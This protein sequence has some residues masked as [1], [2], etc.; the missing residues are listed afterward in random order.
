VRPLTLMI[1]RMQ[2]ESRDAPSRSGNGGL[3]LLTGLIGLAVIANSV[4]AVGYLSTSE[5][6][7]NRAPAPTVA[8]APAPDQ[9]LAPTALSRLL[10]QRSRAVVNHDRD[11]FLRTV[12]PV[13]AAFLADQR[14]LFDNLSRLPLANWSYKPVGMQATGRG[15]WWVQLSVRYRLRGFDVGDVVRRQYVHVVQRPRLGWVVAGNGTAYGLPDE[16]EV[17]DTGRLTVVKGRRSLVLG[18]DAVRSKLRE[19][20]DRVDAGVPVVSGV[21]GSDWARRA[22][23]LVPGTQEQASRLVGQAQDLGQIAA[24]ATVTGEAAH[25]ADRIVVAPTTFPRLNPLG[26]RVVLTHELTHIATGGARDTRTPMWLVEGL[27]DYVGYKDID[28]PV[29]DAARELSE[30]V[31]TGRLPGRLPDQ[32]DF[33]GSSPRLSEAYQEAW[34]ACRMIVERYGEDRLWRLYQAAGGSA[35]QAQGHG[36]GGAA[37]DVEP[38]RGPAAPGPGNRP[39]SPPDTAGGEAGAA[40]PRQREDRALRGVL[41][42]GT[43]AFVAMWRDYL[44]TE[45]GT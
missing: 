29:I 10:E 5:A 2:A 32:R 27:A 7:P 23:V 18:A 39:G 35:G 24:L 44:R 15:G 40:D 37:D 21:V 4:A 38:G 22:V 1:T 34:L 43:T 14:R 20:A 11:A 33:A 13:R 25:P 8:L 42:V 6:P 17:W 16:P 30:E 9:A 31:K 26:R 3:R 19:I 45:L 41:G 28:L 36:P 12:D